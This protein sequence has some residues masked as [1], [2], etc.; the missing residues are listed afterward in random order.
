[1][2]HGRRNFFKLAQLAKAP[3]AIESVRRIDAILIS[4][5][6]STVCRKKTAALSVGASTSAHTPGSASGCK[7]FVNSGSSILR[8]L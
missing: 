4:S 6:Q 1:L 7:L 8:N 2:A 3:L 5:A